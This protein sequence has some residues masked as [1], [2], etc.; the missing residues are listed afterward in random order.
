VRSGYASDVRTAVTEIMTSDLIIL[1][2][3]ASVAEAARVMALKHAGSVLVMDGD[4]LAG[5]FTERDIVRALAGGVSDVGR[6]SPVDRWMTREVVTVNPEATVGEA[7]DVMLSR[8]FRHLVVAAEDGT[9]V[10]VVSMRDLAGKIAK[11]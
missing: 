10:G 6:T 9:A 11:N 2:P 4:R 5:I 1:S 8:G 7:L 3:S